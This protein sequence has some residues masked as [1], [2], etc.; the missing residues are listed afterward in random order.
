MVQIISILIGLYLLYEAME[1]AA[2][3]ERGDKVCR[4]AKYLLVAVIGLRLIV[5]SGQADIWHLVMAAALALFVWPKMLDRIYY[6][7]DHLGDR[8]A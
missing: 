7:I 4:V 8:H 5:E 2:Q 1:A 6:Y 3:M